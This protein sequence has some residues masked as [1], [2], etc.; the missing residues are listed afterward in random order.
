M[1]RSAN[2]V[3]D[4]MVERIARQFHPVR[5]LL[6]GSRAPGDAGP[7]SDVD[8]LVV[9]EK[10]EDKRRTT[11]AIRR[12]LA[13]LPISKDIVVTTPDEINRRGKLVGTVLRRTRTVPWPNQARDR[14]K[15]C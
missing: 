8:P 4:T 1:T 11:H 2:D 7:D 3:L 12:A 15:Q 5:I 10:V 6:F 9:L 14:S 13:D